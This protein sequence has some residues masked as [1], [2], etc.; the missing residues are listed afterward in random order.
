MQKIDDQVFIEAIKKGLFP[1]A[2]KV[3]RLG[4]EFRLNSHTFKVELLDEQPVVVKLLK[5]SKVVTPSQLEDER[6]IHQVLR[7]SGLDL[8]IPQMISSGRL[9]IDKN[10]NF[11]YLVFP[12]I[13]GRDLAAALGDG[14]ARSEEDTLKLLNFGVE[15]IT[16]LSKIGIEH[17]DIKPGNIIKDKSGKY[18]LIDLGIARFVDIPPA[19]FGKIQGPARYLSPEKIACLQDEHP[20]NRRTISFMSDIYSLGVVCFEQL[21][22]PEFNKK[23]N[24]GK[25]GEVAES[26]LNRKLLSIKNDEL[27]SKLSALLELTVSNRVKA[28]SE[29]FDLGNKPHTFSS[30][31]WLWKIAQ[32]A[33]KKYSN[34]HPSDPG[35]FITPATSVSAATLKHIQKMKEKG[36]MS[37]VDPLT[38]RLQV[39]SLNHTGSLIDLPYYKEEL[40]EYFRADAGAVMDF[41]EKVLSYQ[42]SYDVDYIISPYFHVVSPTDPMLDFTFSTYKL[43]STIVDRD[44]IDKPLVFG[45][46]LSQAILKDR[47]YL[48]LI[49]D[50]IVSEPNIKY[51]YLQLDFAKLN[52]CPFDD[53]KSLEGLDHL[54]TNLTVTKGLLVSNIDQ[55]ALVLY[56]RRKFAVGINPQEPRKHSMENLNK[57]RG[58]SFTRKKENIRHRVYIADLFSD[59]DIDRVLKN[60]EF[61]E[62]ESKL[63]M[64]QASSYAKES[65]GASNFKPD[66][67]E[68]RVKHFIESFKSQL[69]TIDVFQSG[70]VE[71]IAKMKDLINHAEVCFK[72]LDDKGVLLDVQNPDRFI[73]SWKSMLEL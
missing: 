6:S 49:L 64:A 52:H 59:L 70:S 14:R 55:S 65:G 26:V 41:T 60:S 42:I 47:K 20:A 15:V 71:R 7:D 61:E 51:V 32:Q 67:V 50:Q 35:G 17:Q 28:C 33:L 54:I 40:N 39:N 13:D 22:G 36:W 30:D 31:L 34:D 68:V 46:M 62:V 4:S 9:V 5:T 44:G 53:L 37:I 72:A 11:P 27:R 45:L 19:E 63:D 69:K 43:A 73:S 12:Y 56:A 58:N 3:V 21:A 25:R 29:I 8:P 57:N 16:E 23:W 66:D 10:T 1:D 48:D 24:I 38:Y 18:T 2:N